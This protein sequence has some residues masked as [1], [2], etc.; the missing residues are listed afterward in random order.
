MVETHPP[1]PQTSTFRHEHG[2]VEAVQLTRENL[3]DVYEWADSKPWFGPD[4]QIDG[5][6]I[7]TLNGRRKA[8][9]GDWVIRSVLGDFYPIKPDAFESMYQPVEQP[10]EQP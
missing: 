8:D 1:L 2:E 9:F 4:R 3:W 10:E 7:W 6:T 5:L